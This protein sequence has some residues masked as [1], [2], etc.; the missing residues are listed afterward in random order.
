MTIKLV[1]LKSGEEV[2]AD[3]K[4]II[5]QERLAALQFCDATTVRIENK[6][7]FNSTGGVEFDV[8]FSPWIPLAKDKDIPVNPDWVV[9]MVDPVS[10]LIEKYQKGLENAKSRKATT[11]GEQPDSSDSTDGSSV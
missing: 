8:H 2:I 9:T 7:V 10:E 6:E 4:E 5:H 3:V 1:L 11:L